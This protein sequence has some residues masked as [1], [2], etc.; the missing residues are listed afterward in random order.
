MHAIEKGSVI[1]YNRDVA[2]FAAIASRKENWEGDL[3]KIVASDEDVV[4]M[5]DE[6]E[7]TTRLFKS[8]NVMEID[9]MVFSGENFDLDFD[10]SEV[11]I[12]RPELS[13]DMIDLTALLFPDTFERGLLFLAVTPVS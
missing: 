5:D 9:Q 11:Q 4:I 10:V 13:K 12:L 8:G 2:P 1:R 6:L 3:F 7:L